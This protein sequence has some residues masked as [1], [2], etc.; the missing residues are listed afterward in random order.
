MAEVARAFSTGTTKNEKHTALRWYLDPKSI[1]IILTVI[2][3]SLTL[4]A[5]RLFNDYINW[6]HPAMGSI[7]AGIATALLV[8][9][10]CAWADNQYGVSTAVLLGLVTSSFTV[11]GAPLRGEVV[12]PLIIAFYSFHV[13]FAYAEAETVWPPLYEAY[14]TRTNPELNKA[15]APVAKDLQEMALDDYKVD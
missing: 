4:P 2:V 1:V 10:I 13:F 7:I 14:I 5:W 15:L 9:P 6:M 8:F 3:T 12:A 11:Y